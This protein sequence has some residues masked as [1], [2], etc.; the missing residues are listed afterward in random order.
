MSEKKHIAVLA[1]GVD[2]LGIV[3]A[4]TGV[5]CEEHG[6]NIESSQ[7]T[8]VGGHFAVNLVASTTVEIDCNRLKADLRD[9]GDN[10]IELV[11]VSELDDF[12]RISRPE[13]SHSIFVYADDRPGL[14]HEVTRILV[15]MNVNIRSLSS[16]CSDEQDSRCVNGLQ[17]TLPTGLGEDQA[18]KT[19]REAVAADVEITIEPIRRPD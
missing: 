10:A 19:M 1:L 7:M 16:S 15:T 18:E 14:L 2:T 4:V 17:V 3:A 11:H 12:S 5:L 6:L 8:S 13:P 9:A